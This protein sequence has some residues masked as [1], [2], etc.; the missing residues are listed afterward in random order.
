MRSPAIMKCRCNRW[1]ISNLTEL[2]DALDPCMSNQI[3]GC[4]PPSP[5]MRSTSMLPPATVKNGR[6]PAKTTSTCSSSKGGPSGMDWTTSWISGIFSLN[7]RSDFVRNHLFV[8]PSMHCAK[9]IICERRMPTNIF[10]MVVA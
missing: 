6:T 1:E 2:R 4:N 5:S 8:S 10:I 7:P 3:V 9:K